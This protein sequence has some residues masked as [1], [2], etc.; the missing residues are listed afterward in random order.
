ML[1]KG[2]A[3][4]AGASFLNKKTYRCTSLLIIVCYLQKCYYF[5]IPRIFSHNTCIITAELLSL[6]PCP[7]CCGFLST[8]SRCFR[9]MAGTPWTPQRAPRPPAL[10]RA[11]LCAFRPWQ[12]S[13]APSWGSP[14]S[15]APSLHLC[16]DQGKWPRG[17]RLGGNG[18]S[19]FLLPRHGGSRG[20]Q[21]D[22]T[23]EYSQSRSPPRSPR[24]QQAKCLRG[25]HSC[26]GP[27]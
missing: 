7:R 22:P 27:K 8:I 9:G 4:Q 15:H 1:Q 6:V 3:M 10:L 23:D 13:S 14:T 21:R 16:R 2:Y 17:E 18:G 5:P 24:R 25:M 11:F 20:R 26:S 19:A 12:R